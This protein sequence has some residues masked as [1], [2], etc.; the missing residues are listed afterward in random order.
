MHPER[1]TLQGSLS[2]NLTLGKRSL[3][4]HS[5]LMLSLLVASVWEELSIMVFLSF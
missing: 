1:A 3:A 5:V 4:F 2:L